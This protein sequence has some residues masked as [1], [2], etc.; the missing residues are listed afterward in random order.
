MRDDRCGG[1]GGPTGQL[2]RCRNLYDEG[3]CHVFFIDC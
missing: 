1:R 2:F 3:K